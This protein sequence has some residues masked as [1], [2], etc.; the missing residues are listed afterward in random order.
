MIQS[1][2]LFASFTQDEARHF[3]SACRFEQH[4]AG[5]R[6][7]REGEP[8]RELYVLLSG[9]VAV[10]RFGGVAE[11]ELAR[12]GPGDTFGELALI[13][14]GDRS[15]SVVALTDVR[16]LVFERASLFRLPALETKLYR[17]LAIMMAHRLRE[18]DAR[19]AE[20]AEQNAENSAFEK[21][22]SETQR[23]FVG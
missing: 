4:A 10:R 13:D 9:E 3:L 18:T 16:V 8:G 12:L 19:L 6:L 17:N 11:H 5:E 23:F 1:V 7:L 22:A 2:R 14:F 20:A 21:L 15:A